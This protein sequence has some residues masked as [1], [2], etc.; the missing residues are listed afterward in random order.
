MSRML[1]VK[2]AAD[3]RNDYLLTGLHDYGKTKG[4]NSE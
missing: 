3:L 4:K 2:A 1:C